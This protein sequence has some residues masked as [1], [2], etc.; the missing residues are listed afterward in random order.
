MSAGYQFLP[1]IQTVL[2]VQNS[3]KD[4]FLL[5]LKGTE[6]STEKHCINK[7]LLLEK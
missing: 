4:F 3:F 7:L 6:I 5:I 2:R 1:T